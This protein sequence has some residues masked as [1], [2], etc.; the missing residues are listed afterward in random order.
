MKHIQKSKTYR[1][2][3]ADLSARKKNFSQ[4]PYPIKKKIAEELGMD[5]NNAKDRSNIGKLWGK[6]RGNRAM[7]KEAKEM[8]AVDKAEA[9]EAAAATAPAPARQASN[10]SAGLE[11]AVKAALAAA[12]NANQAATSANQAVE[13]LAGTVGEQGKQIV[14]QGKQITDLKDIASGHENRLTNVE[15]RMGV[16]ETRQ[17]AADGRM[18]AMQETLNA[19]SPLNIR[20]L[21]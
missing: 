3:L 8:V 17:D 1:N 10:N 12:T 9:E 5:I 7:I 6:H 4:L 13:N 11:E 2:S 18:D 20:C 19:P 21:A 16:A 14:E 15:D